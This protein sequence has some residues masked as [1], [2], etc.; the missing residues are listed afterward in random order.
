MCVELHTTLV[1]RFLCEI[2][3]KEKRS[4][5]RFLKSAMMN[6]AVFLNI[7][8][9]SW[10]LSA[11]G[12]VGLLQTGQRSQRSFLPEP[13]TPTLPRSP[14]PRIPSSQQGLIE[15]RRTIRTEVWSL[16]R[17]AVGVSLLTL[18]L[19]GSPP[20][21]GGCIISESLWQKTL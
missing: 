18:A 1:E 4:S 9:R 7:C 19:E 2:Q 21:V 8:Q 20:N 12:A 5:K 6:G 10:C 11:R 13:H 3:F 17:A 15:G 16:L 14:V